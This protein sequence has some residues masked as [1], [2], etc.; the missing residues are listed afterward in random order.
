MSEDA[1][2]KIK[3][4]SLICFSE[5]EYSDY[6]YTGHFVALEDITPETIE[7]AKTVALDMERTSNAVMEEWRRDPNRDSSTYPGYLDNKSAFI[8]SL[9]R[10]GVLLDIPVR[11]IHLGSYG[12]LSVEL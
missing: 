1:D 12:E 7:K 11:E 4:G 9:V 2:R 3:A 8:A 10:M 6:G 5:G